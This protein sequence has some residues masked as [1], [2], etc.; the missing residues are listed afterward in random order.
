[1][2]DMIQFWKMIL[3]VQIGFSNNMSWWFVE[4][5]YVFVNL[6]EFWDEVFLEFVNLNDLLVI[7]INGLDFV[8]VKVG[9]VIGDVVVNSFSSIES[10]NY[11]YSFVFYILEQEVLFG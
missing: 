4:V 2:F 5:G 3:G 11:S 9:D 10:C 1:M 7:G 8:V 6:L